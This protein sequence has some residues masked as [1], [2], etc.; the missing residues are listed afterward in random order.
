MEM[1]I[2][3]K[4]RWKSHIKNVLVYLVKTENNKLYGC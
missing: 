2:H 1:F 4:M 3:F